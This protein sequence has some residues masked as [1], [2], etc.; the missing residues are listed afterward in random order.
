VTI[1]IKDNTLISNIS[2][3]TQEEHKKE[4]N[5][6]GYAAIYARQSSKT[7]SFSI[8][9][10]V[11]DCKRYLNDN[12]LL[13]YNVYED[14]ESGRKDFETRKSFV[15]LLN[16]MYAGMFKTVVVIR[17]DRLSRRIDDFMKIKNIFKAHDVNVIYVK[18]PQ[19]N[20]NEENYISNF[21]QNMVMA[22][23]TFEPD[24]I[25]D[26][27]SF[28]KAQA[29]KAGK[30]KFGS[31][32]P[33][34]F[35]KDEDTKQLIIDE[36]RAKLIKNVF[37][38]YLKFK[39]DS[40]NNKLAY[41]V[42]YIQSTENKILTGENKQSNNENQ[43]SVKSRKFTASF[44]Y[45]L[46]Q[47]PI[48]AGLILLD[49]EITLKEMIYYDEQTRQYT[50]KEDNFVECTNVK[51]KIIEE[52]YWKKVVIKHF[53]DKLDE[54]KELKSYLFKNLLYCSECSTIIKK[55]EETYVCK[56]NCI[57]TNENTL[58]KAI[59]GQIIIDTDNSSIEYIIQKEI[60]KVKVRINSK[61]IELRDLNSNLR[62]ALYENIINQSDIS[63]SKSNYI[64]QVNDRKILKADID[65]LGEH[66]RQLKDRMESINLFK[67]QMADFSKQE[68]LD[69]I[70]NNWEFV[71]TILS[72]IIVKAVLNNKSNDK[73]GVKIKY[74][75]G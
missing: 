22:V 70:K 46:I 36:K 16:D 52:D 32:L 23:S 45:D 30:Y 51:G 54:P 24:N 62:K 41:I 61:K 59:I 58:I 13:L 18:E 55:I 37:D 74:T 35:L 28:G 27:T 66:L 38:K 53:E 40:Q 25:A 29:R 69:F 48:Y 68:E 6:Y 75:S 7:D 19:L 47:R 43:N 8:P 5:P 49:P 42:E 11:E 12:N 10:Q 1:K 44:I 15:K 21:I 64:N 50:F 73:Y 20:F 31:S 9:S 65:N 63:T 33:Y 57:N 17:M 71:H 72:K 56:H 4:F 60:D 39:T 3:I 67:F 2:N 26:R 34:G 14:K